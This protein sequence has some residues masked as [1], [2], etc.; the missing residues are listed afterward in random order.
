MAKTEKKQD[1]LKKARE[2]LIR[3]TAEGILGAGYAVKGVKHLLR[4]SEGRG[5]LIKLT[6][7][8]IGLG[9]GFVMSVPEIVK[10]V[11]E[12]KSESNDKSRKKSRK[13]KID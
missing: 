2:H 9:L 10:Q 1:E 5:Q 13:I 7:R 3:A 12:Y 4:D 8:F 6:G 11:K